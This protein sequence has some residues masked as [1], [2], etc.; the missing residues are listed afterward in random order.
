[1]VVILL[2]IRVVMAVHGFNDKGYTHVLNKQR[3]ESNTAFCIRQHGHKGRHKSFP[4]VIFIV[5]MIVADVS[6]EMYQVCSKTP[7]EATRNFY[8]TGGTGTRYDTL[9]VELLPVVPESRIAI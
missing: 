5:I 7:P 6:W 9:P 1:M 2:V 3:W 8:C 4:A